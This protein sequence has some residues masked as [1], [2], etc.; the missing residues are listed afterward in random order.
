MRS[1]KANP[2]NP[3]ALRLSPERPKSA[4]EALLF[5]FALANCLKRMLQGDY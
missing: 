4:D 5:S 2:L 3:D 1:K